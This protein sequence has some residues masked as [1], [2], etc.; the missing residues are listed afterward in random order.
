MRYALG[1]E[2]DG[3]AYSGWQRQ[4]FFDAT[5]Q[6]AVESALGQVAAHELEVVCAGRTDKGVHAL[7]QVIHFDTTARRDAHAWLAGGN[8][9]LPPDIRL[10]WI[11]EVDEDFHARHSALER[12]YRYVVKCD[13]QPSALWANRLHWHRQ[14]LDAKRM[15]EAAQCLVGEHDFSSFRSSECQSK[16]PF[17]CIHEISVKQRGRWIAIDVRGNAFLH[18]MV[19]NIVGSLLMVGDGRRDGVWLEQVLKAKDRRLAGVTAPA[20]GLYLL[21][22]RYPEHYHLSMLTDSWLT[23]EFS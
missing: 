19:R 17:R 21:Y 11:Q 8:R 9:Y 10:Q 23:D 1:L 4:P 7:N 3:T 14:V 6:Q 13:E 5:L 15:H 22:A 12:A 18:H 2:Y 20:Q 16:T